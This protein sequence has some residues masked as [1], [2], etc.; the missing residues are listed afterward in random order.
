MFRQPYDHWHKGPSILKYSKNGL[1]WSHELGH[2]EIVRGN[3]FLFVEIA[4]FL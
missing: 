1:S 2:D 3:K 4:M